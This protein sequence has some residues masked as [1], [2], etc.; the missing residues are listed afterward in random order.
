MLAEGSHILEPFAAHEATDQYFQ[1][2]PD[3]CQHTIFISMLKCT[4][5]AFVI[6]VAPGVVDM[7]RKG[8]CQ[9]HKLRNNDGR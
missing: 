4:Y 3:V 6:F 1:V 5:L 8:I 2:L 9:N 7:L